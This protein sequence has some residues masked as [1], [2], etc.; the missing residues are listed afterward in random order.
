MY[1]IGIMVLRKIL[2]SFT[3]LENLSFHVQFLECSCYFS[4]LKMLQIYDST[5]CVRSSILSLFSWNFIQIFPP[6][7]AN[8]NDNSKNNEM[9]IF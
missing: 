4:A 1:S 3:F 2:F 9:N 6:P 5:S 8:F 7:L